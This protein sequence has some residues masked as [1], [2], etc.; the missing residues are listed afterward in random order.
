VGGTQSW[1]AEKAACQLRGRSKDKKTIFCAPA[2]KAG[3]RKGRPAQPARP[4]THRTSNH[5]QAQRTCAV[6]AWTGNS[7]EAGQLED[8]EDSQNDTRRS[9][10][11]ASC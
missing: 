1:G 10:A 3:V 6:S 2:S 7:R 4:G 5:I 8:E 11:L 9:E